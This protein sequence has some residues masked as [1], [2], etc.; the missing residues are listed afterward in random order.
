MDPTT[1]TA[2]QL[3][4]LIRTREISAVEALQSHLDRVA[5]HN[6]AINAVI[7][8][9]EQRALD[10]ARAADD[11]LSHGESWGPLHGLPMTLKDAH[12][13]AGLRTPS[14]YE[15]LADYIPTEDSTVTARL[16]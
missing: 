6:S 10:R 7:T 14:G 3:L 11:A 16:K 4:Q 13:T 2:T 8:L 5:Q 12:S 15:P 9:D 1:L